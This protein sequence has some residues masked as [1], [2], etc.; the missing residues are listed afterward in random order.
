VAISRERK[1]S[2]RTAGPLRSSRSSFRPTLRG[3]R[4][5]SPGP[6]INVSRPRPCDSRPRWSFRQRRNPLSRPRPH[7]PGPRT[8]CRR[9]RSGSRRPSNRHPNRPPRAPRITPPPAMKPPF[10]AT[11]TASGSAAWATPPTSA[12]A[13]SEADGTRPAPRWRAAGRLRRGGGGTGD[14]IARTGAVRD[15]REAAGATEIASARRR[16]SIVW[17][18]EASVAPEVGEEVT[19][20]LPRTTFR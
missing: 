6:G 3:P 8:S 15:P 10:A 4:P 17:S 9:P 2:S 16:L 7:P 20:T 14:T 5:S 11:S 13:S 19:R 12:V 18:P 1:P